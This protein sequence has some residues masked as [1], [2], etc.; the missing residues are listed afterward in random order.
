[1]AQAQNGDTV[2][3]HYTGKLEDGTVF[4]S[5]EGGDPLEFQLGQQQILPGIEKAVVGMDVGESK[6]TTIPADDALGPHRPDLVAVVP[7][8]EL[9]DDIQPEVGQQLLMREASGQELRV[10]VT[11]TDADSVTLDGNHPLAGRD[12]TFDLQLVEIG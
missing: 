1:M 10:L 12:L 8:A 5:S 4:Q 6:T 2:K 3:V 11:D 9:P 7:R